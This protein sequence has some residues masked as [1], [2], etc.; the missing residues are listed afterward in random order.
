M[1]K[2]E[3]LVKKF[4]VTKLSNPEKKLDCIVLEFDDP[5]ARRG[6]QAWAE[7]MLEAG[8]HRCAA[9]VLGKLLRIEG[10]DIT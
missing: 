1:S 7:A 3:G 2:Q 4:E 6:I 9:E 5:I 8:Y 10:G